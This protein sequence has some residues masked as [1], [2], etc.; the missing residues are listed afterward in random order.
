MPPIRLINNHGG[1]VVLTGP[2]C[3][4]KGEYNQNYV[5]L[6]AINWQPNGGMVHFCAQ[7]ERI[8]SLSS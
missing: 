4:I 3:E 5:Q 8:G 7:M 1:D 2:Q 6:P